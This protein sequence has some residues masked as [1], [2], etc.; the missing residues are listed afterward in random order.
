MNENGF[1]RRQWAAIFAGLFITALI[2]I[3]GMIWQYHGKE[4]NAFEAGK[5]ECKDQI[6]YEAISM[7]VAHIDFKD[8]TGKFQRVYLAP[9]PEEWALK[10]IK[11]PQ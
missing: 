9:V 7:D 6:L 1:N 3:S 5:Q 4:D 11:I 10:H 2:A 8:E